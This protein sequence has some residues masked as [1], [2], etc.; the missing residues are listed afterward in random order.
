MGQSWSNGW[1]AEVDGVDLGPPTLIDGYANG[2]YVDP[3]VV[4][5]G[6][7]AFTISWTPQ[8][9]VWV[10]IGVSAAAMVACLALMLLAGRRPRPLRTLAPD[11]LRPVRPQLGW[12]WPLDRRPVPDAR[13]PGLAVALALGAGFLVAVGLNVA[14]QWGFP[15]VAVPL[16]IALVVALRQPRWRS[17]LGLAAAGC[18][19]LTGAYVVV[20]QHRNRYLPDFT[21]PTHFDRVNIL[22]LLAIFLLLGEAILDIARTRREPREP[23]APEPPR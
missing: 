19:L 6:P 14:N 7:L 8:R 21:W 16:A 20:Q 23:P 9:L 11:A 13:R 18:Y 5:T 22:A 4:G 10:F 3:A 1:K 12:P 15:L 17:W 2:W